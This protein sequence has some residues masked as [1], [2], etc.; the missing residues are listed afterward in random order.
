MLSS[1][2]GGRHISI[3]V[4]LGADTRTSNRLW[5][6]EESVSN[7]TGS[8]SAAQLLTKGKTAVPSVCGRHR[9]PGLICL[10][11][12]SVPDAAK[13]VHRLKF[14]VESNK[15][16]LTSGDLKHN[17]D[18]LTTLSVLFMIIRMFA[19]RVNILCVCLFSGRGVEGAVSSGLHQQD[20]RQAQMFP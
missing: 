12:S 19:W 11:C 6:V 3:H 17:N 10:R 5:S 1:C 4:R 20:G 8:L 9:L 15:D 18:S 16:Q 13:D 2:T 14:A 7:L